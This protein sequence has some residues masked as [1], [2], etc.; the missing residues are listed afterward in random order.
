MF[1]AKTADEWFEEYGDSHKNKINKLIHWIMV[2]SIYFTVI[3]LLWDV[4]RLDWMGSPEWV[5]WA[6]MA[7]IP[8]M[9]FYFRMSIPILL[10]MALFTVLCFV[11]AL[12]LTANVAMPLWQLSLIIFVVAWIFQFIGHKIEGK[13]PSFFKDLQFLLVGPAWLMGFIYR[14]IGI[15]Y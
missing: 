5:N 12:W 1:E 7:M 13:K 9:A 3:G 10:G 2:P 8:A 15:K 4:P 11:I 6:T 14:A